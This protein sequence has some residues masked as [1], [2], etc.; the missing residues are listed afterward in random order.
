MDKK[1]GWKGTIMQNNYEDICKVRVRE[2][3]NQKIE[4]EKNN[5]PWIMTLEFNF[6]TIQ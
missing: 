2:K 4:G 3:N 1:M 6:T 5:E